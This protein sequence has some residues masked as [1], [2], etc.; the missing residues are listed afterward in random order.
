MIRRR[1]HV[2]VVATAPVWLV[3][4]AAVTLVAAVVVPNLVG[5]RSLKVLSG[6]MEPRIHTGDIVIGRWIPPAE[7][8][9]GDVVTFRKPGADTLITH[10]VRL[11]RVQADGVYVVTKGDANHTVE[12]S[13]ARRAHA[14]RGPCIA[15]PR[16]ATSSSGSARASAAGPS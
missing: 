5:G 11:V 3:A 7:A 10:R 8:L 14:S 12:D 15:C 13:P 4:G 1:P 2:H 9:P 6:S 16:P